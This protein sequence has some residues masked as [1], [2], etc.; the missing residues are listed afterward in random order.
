MTWLT[1]RQHRFQLYLAAAL[2]AAFAAV[3]VISGRQMAAQFHNAAAACAAGRGCRQLGGL[4]MGSHV[5]GF[6]VIATLGAPLLVGM[7]WGA[8]LLAAEL[9]A[10]TFR[11]AWMQSVTRRRWLAV[12]VGWLLLAAAVWGG[13]ISALVAWWYSPANATDPE[14]FNPGRFDLAGIVPVAYALFAMV[15]GI[16]AGAL[17]RRTLPAMAVTFAG[18]VA[19]RVAIVLWLRPHY[20]TAVT[21]TYNMIRGF[22]L[23]GAYWQLAQGVYDPSGHLVVMGDNQPVFDGVPASLLPSSCAQA[24][25]TVPASCTQALARYRGFITY[26]PAG[27]YWAFQGI[28]AGIFVLL[29]AILLTVTAVVLLRRDA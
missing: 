19:V 24:G 28:E 26:Q 5:V 27:R 14:Q 8:P 6:L 10:G 12:K 9:D 13:V 17:L 3:I 2:L 11:F 18:F 20:M 1:W 23:P 21:T 15:L 16:C 22:T 29:A 7:F 4:F 25:N